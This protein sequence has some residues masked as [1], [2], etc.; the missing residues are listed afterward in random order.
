MTKAQKNKNTIFSIVIFKAGK[1]KFTANLWK[2]FPVP[3]NCFLIYKNRFFQ[4]GN[5]ACHMDASH[6]YIIQSAISMTESATHD[7]KTQSL[8][9]N[10]SWC[11]DN[12]KKAQGI[13]CIETVKG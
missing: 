9:H 8:L 12:I 11:S 6:I 13:G 1:A 10:S 4:S 3:H 7:E 2:P 5:F